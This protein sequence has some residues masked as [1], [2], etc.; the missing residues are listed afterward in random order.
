MATFQNFKDN[1]L[2]Y[3]VGLIV[4]MVWYD[5]REV[6]NDVKTLIIQTSESKA[7]I[8]ALERSVYKPTSALHVPTPP[9]KL[10]LQVDMRNVLAVINKNDL[11]PKEYETFN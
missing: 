4:G 3:V 7:K 11:T 1:A 6:K 8:E 2:S 5:V 10:P 9:Y